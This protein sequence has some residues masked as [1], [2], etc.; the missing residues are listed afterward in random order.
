MTVSRYTKKLLK[1]ARLAAEGGATDREI[2][3]DFGISERTLNRWKSRHPDFAKALKL[4]KHAADARVEKSLYE[5]A[6]GYSYDQERAFLP[7]G[8]REPVI[9]TVRQ[10]VPGDVKAAMYWLK[11]R[12]PDKWRDKQEFEVSGNDSLAET[13]E[14][15]RKRALSK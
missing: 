13:L 14:A 2:A 12:R 1:P 11:N 6:L 10:H 7:L 15:A 8:R 4:G 5:R 9:V 3:E